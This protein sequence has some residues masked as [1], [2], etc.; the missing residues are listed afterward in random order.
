MNKAVIFDVGGVILD[1]SPRYLY[2]ELFGGDTP[3]MERF[4]TNV[5][6]TAWILAQDAG[7]PFAEGVAALSARFP[8]QADLIAAFD[9]RWDDM[10]RGE[11]AGT[12]ALIERLWAR[13]VP[14]YGLTNFSPEKWRQVRP[15]YAVFG[16][17][18]GIVV[19][20]DEGLV[21]PDPRIYRTLLDRYG[22]AAGDCLFIDDSPVNVAG[23]E[24]V[25]MAAVRF[26]DAPQLAAELERRGYL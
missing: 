6:N 21:K 16:R 8:E 4:L 20:G 25:G 7:R 12:A 5:C 1:W 2:R 18:D 22:R 17:F 10:L 14:L 24:T 9:A 19:S 3:A 26:E 13:G 11:V 15:R 23:A